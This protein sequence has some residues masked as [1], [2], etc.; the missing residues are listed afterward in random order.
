MAALIVLLFVISA[1]EITLLVQF[2]I[3]DINAANSSL[4]EAGMLSRSETPNSETRVS[5]TSI[6]SIFTMISIVPVVVIVGDDFP[7]RGIVF[8]RQLHI[9]QKG[10]P[11]KI[12]L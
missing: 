7:S 8:Q 6:E 3:E 9:V 11:G 2:E 12:L 5:S 4:V 1:Y 10:P